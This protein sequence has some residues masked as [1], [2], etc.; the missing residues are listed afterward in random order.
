MCDGNTC[1]IFRFY[2]KYTQGK[3]N[4]YLDKLFKPGTATPDWAKIKRNP[5]LF[6]EEKIDTDTPMGQLEFS[7]LKVSDNFS[8]SI[9][10]NPITQSKNIQL[11]VKDQIPNGATGSW[12]IRLDNPVIAE[13]LGLKL[14]A[15][16]ATENMEGEGVAMLI[17][18]LSGNGDLESLDISAAATSRNTISITGNESMK[19][20]EV[21]LDYFP[22]DVRQ[23]A[24]I[25]QILPNTSGTAYIDD[26]RLDV[27]EVVE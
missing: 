27:M 25:F 9:I 21:D 3:R 8:Q 11:T 23:I 24:L 2:D 17:R 15:K 26:I 14:Q 6:F 16:I 12:V 13:G 5:T 7:D 10:T 18:T 22:S 20:Y 1:N 19:M 4:Y